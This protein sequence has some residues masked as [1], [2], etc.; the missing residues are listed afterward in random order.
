MTLEGFRKRIHK[1]YTRYQ[2][3]FN[4]NS[5]IVSIYTGTFEYLVD[6]CASLSLEPYRSDFAAASTVLSLNGTILKQYLFFVYNALWDLNE[7][8]L[9]GV[10]AHELQHLETVTAMKLQ[11]SRWTG[12]QEEVINDLKCLE[13]GFGKQVLLAHR[14]LEGKHGYTHVPAFYDEVFPF[15]KLTLSEVVALLKARNKRHVIQK[16]AL[17]SEISKLCVKRRIKQPSISL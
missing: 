9:T 4:F 5:D 2:D 6:K 16:Y 11:V 13:K 15:G 12:D 1:I 17:E 3:L 7:E 14:I 8:A 10:V